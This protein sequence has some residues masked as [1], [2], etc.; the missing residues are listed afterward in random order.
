LIKFVSNLIGS[1]VSKISV[2]Y[3]LNDAMIRRWKKEYINL[4]RPLFT[5]AGVVALSQEESRIRKLK[6]K[7]ISLV[8]SSN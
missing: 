8:Q 4:D 6:L 3:S 1:P 2:D 5:G 7:A